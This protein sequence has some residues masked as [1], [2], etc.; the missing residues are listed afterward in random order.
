MGLIVVA[1]VEGVCAWEGVQ[2]DQGAHDCAQKKDRE[3]HHGVERLRANVGERDRLQVAQCDFRLGIAVPASCAEVTHAPKTKRHHESG[4]K[5]GERVARDAKLIVDE[6]EGRT[7][8][9]D[10]EWCG[11]QREDA[12]Q[13]Q[14]SEKEEARSIKQHQGDEG[15]TDELK[16]HATSLPYLYPVSV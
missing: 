13:S 9:D 8:A 11:T 16:P 7:N 6:R 15:C 1:G 14:T 10:K 2:K 12:G 3:Q 5:Y 4:A